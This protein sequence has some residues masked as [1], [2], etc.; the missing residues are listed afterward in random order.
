ME[1]VLSIVRSSLS[2]PPRGLMESQETTQ[3][4]QP[5][6]LFFPELQGDEDDAQWEHD[7]NDVQF[8]DEGEGAGVEGDLDM[9]ED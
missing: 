8:V 7:V 2:E 6:H 4:R 5:E 1:E 9:E 3:G